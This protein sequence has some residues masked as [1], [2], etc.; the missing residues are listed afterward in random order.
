MRVGIVGNGLAGVMAAKT[1]REASP[2]A[3]IEVFAQEGHHYY[4]RPNLIEYLAGKLPYNRLFAFPESWYEE[5][6]I[7]VHL[8]TPAAAISADRLE[9]ATAAGEKKAFDRLLLCEGA[10]AARLPI[11][12]ADKKGVFTLRTLDD[13]QAIL[14]YLPAHGDVAV[15][16]GGLLGLEMA[17]ALAHRGAKVRVVEFFDRLLPRQLD[18]QAAGLLKDW[19]EKMGLAVR[20]STSTEEV[21][22]EG[23]LSGLLFKG[24]D[25]IGASMAILAAGV[26]PNIRLAQEAGL[27]TDRGVVVD[28]LLQTSRPN[29]FAA[30]DNTSHRGRLYGIIPASFDQ[31]R[32]A[33]ANLLGQNKPYGGTVM[34]NTLKVAG[35]YV[36]SVGTVNPEGPGFEEIRKEDRDRGIYKKVVLQ[37]GA[38]VG[39]I[40]M[41]TKQGAD[42]IAKA[43]AK[44]ADVTRS[45]NALLEDDFDLGLL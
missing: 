12:G 3:E 26:Q 25:S 36:T 44:K 33:A 13:A 23:E 38:L 42:E 17:R 5:R 22:G 11:R 29:I 40:W 28:D 19:V 7:D 18:T 27:T 20:L 1:L 32:L 30:G 9:I 10:S 35:L 41:G 2:E 34:S 24:G 8:K 16:G 39:A 37:A 4:P 31:A 14:D 43:V 6:R 15:I 45:K 21:R